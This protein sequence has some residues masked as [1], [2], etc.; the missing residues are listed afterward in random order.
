MGEGG[1]N[2]VRQ[3]GLRK[4]LCLKDCLLDESLRC[5]DSGRNGS[6]LV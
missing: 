5:Y 2:S 1:W 6:V 4:P 3:G